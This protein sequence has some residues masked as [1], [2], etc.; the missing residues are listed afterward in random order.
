[1]R[2]KKLHNKSIPKKHLHK[3]S[4]SKIVGSKRII[5]YIPDS[6]DELISQEYLS[7][8]AE[9]ITEEILIDIKETS[10]SAVKEVITSKISRLYD[11]IHNTERKKLINYSLLFLVFTGVVSFLAINSSNNINLSN[12]TNSVEVVIMDETTTTLPI[13]ITTSTTLSSV[14]SSTTSTTLTPVTSTTLPLVR[15]TNVKEAQTQLKKLF[16]YQGEID[17]VNGTYTKLAIKE[18]QKRAGLKID[19]VL[20]PNTKS[21]L[22]SGEEAYI[23]IGGQETVDLSQFEI[24]DETQDLQEKLTE[25]NIYTGDIDGVFGFQTMISLKEFQ[26]KAG[27]KVDGI[28]GANSKAALKK[29]E[30]SYVTIETE[31]VEESIKSETVT[32]SNSTLTVDLKNYNPNS[33]CI[34]GYVNNLNI[35]VPDP[36]FYPVFVFRYGNVAQ[37]N[38]QS[39]LDAYLNQNWSLTKEKTYSSL[40]KVPTQ[41]YSD[42]YNSPI[43]G[44]PMPS[45]SNNSIV[46]GIKNDNNVRAR[47]QSGPQVA[48]AVVEVLVEGGM[49]RFINIFYQSDTTY[50]GPIRSARPTD[51]TVLRPVGGVLVASGATG[52]LIPEIV[53]MGVPVISDRRPEYFRISSR[54]APHNLYAD[55]EKLKQHAINKGYKKYSNPQPLFPWGNPSQSNW[56]SNSYLKLTFSSYT[57]TTWTWNGSSYAR[58]YYDAYKNSSNDNVHYWTDKNGNQGQITTTTVIALFC[59]PYTHPLQLPSVKTVGEGRA[60]ILHKGK[61]LDARW[62]RGSNLDPFH[63]VDSNDNILYVPKGKVWISLVPNTKNPSFG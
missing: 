20:G 16:I 13:Q 15:V 48:D 49:T 50:H 14:T 28:Y 18:F 8:V 39:E 35:W 57:S 38:S 42:G 26:K 53:D 44:L 23:A 19:G 3:K 47:P 30:E 24:T 45:G 40:G 63:I 10:D 21:A 52:G 58:T 29:G 32:S 41:N 12:P 6:L 37:V 9:S 54:N 62:K 22:E 2:Y 11:F 7:P 55:T 1:M 46:I 33:T 56:K 59:E 36:C 61:L 4:K 34:N 17:G 31:S 60:I 5:T 43:N 51:P 25:L 27:L